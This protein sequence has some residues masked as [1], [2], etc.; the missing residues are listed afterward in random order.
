MTPAWKYTHSEQVLS[1][2]SW[3]LQSSAF[4]ATSS[5]SVPAQPVCAA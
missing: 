2:V 4:E 1:Q 5:A 3:Q